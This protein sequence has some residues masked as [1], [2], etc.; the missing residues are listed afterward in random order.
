[1]Y[2][3]EFSNIKKNTLNKMNSLNNDKIYNDYKSFLLG[4]ESINRNIDDELNVLFNGEFISEIIWDYK[5]S[6][7]RKFIYKQDSN[8]ISKTIDFK[9]QK[10]I[11]ETNYNIVENQED[12]LNFIIS[13]KIVS[14]GLGEY[15]IYSIQEYNDFEKIFRITYYSIN[16][17]IIGVIVREFEEDFLKLI[18]EKWYI[19]DYNR[20]IREFNSIFDPKS[21]K[22]IWIEE[23]YK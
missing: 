11:L 21:D 6:Y 1:M 15:G 16:N 10:K 14:E 22:Y 5:D 18:S 20:K 3:N 4:I 12:F 2:N 23:K 19:G 13:N 7:K 9:K 8:E 17:K